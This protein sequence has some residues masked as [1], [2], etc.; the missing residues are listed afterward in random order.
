MR[1]ENS[2]LNSEHKRQIQSKFAPAGWLEGRRIK[3]R[4]STGIAVPAQLL[5]QNAHREVALYSFI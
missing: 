5:I 1:Y 2:I 4:P 3:M